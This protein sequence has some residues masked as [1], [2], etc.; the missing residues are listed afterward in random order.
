M[1][2]RIAI[3]LLLAVLFASL[4]PAAAQAPARFRVAWV[5]LDSAKSNSAVLT[6]FREGMAELGNVEGRNVVIDA[7]WGEGSVERMEKMAGEVIRSR[8][9]VIV[10]QGGSALTPIL[11]TGTTIPIVFGMSADPVLAKVVTSYARPGANVTGITLFAE[12]VTGKRLALLKEMLPGIT[13][14]A[15]IANPQHPGEERELAAARRVGSSI[16]LNLH[17]YP[18]RNDDEMNAALVEIKASR[19]EAIV[20]FSDGLTLDNASRLGEFSERTGIPV[21]GGWAT[22]AQRGSLMTYG[23]VFTEVY[24]RVAYYVDQIRKGVKPGDLPIEQPTRLALVIN[25]KAARALGLTIPK[26]VLVRADT[27]IQ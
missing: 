18:V 17:Y 1:N 3:G 20:V 23:P 19:I 25:L 13:R 24:R 21:T 22:F 12:E 7:W 9:D 6:A 27:V 8:P 5:S 15:I 26:S 11:R 14:V 10:T 16:G 2:Q 4:S